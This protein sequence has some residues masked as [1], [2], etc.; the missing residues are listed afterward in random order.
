MRSMNRSFLFAAALAV[1]GTASAQQWAGLIDPQRAVDWSQAGVPGGIPSR[2]TICSTLNPGATS[3]Q[4]NSAIASCPAN[5]VVYLNAGTYTLSGGINFNNKSNVT[6]RGAG[7]NQTIINFSGGADCIGIEAD[8][9]VGNSGYADPASPPFS[10][11]WTGGL[12]KGSTTV[13]LSSTSGL[14]V[15]QLL[16]LD[17]LNE[18][19]DTGDIWNCST[20]GTCSNEGPA[21]GGRNNRGQ[22]QV[23]RVTAVSGNNVSISPGVA[24]PNFRSGQSP[25]AWTGYTPIQGVGIED[26]RI[27]N[28]QSGANGIV[29]LTAYASWVKNVTSTY[30]GRAHVWV[31]LGKNITVRDSYFYEGNSHASQSYGV[32]L[33]QASDVLVENN[34]IDRVTAALIA[35]G[36]ATGSVIA[37]NYVYQTVYAT[38]SWMIPS[39][40]HHATGVNMMLHEGNDSTGW[41]GDNVHGPGVMLTLFRNRFVGSNPGKVETSQT[42]PIQPYH[43]WRYLNV[44]GNVLGDGVT[45]KVY[46]CSPASASTSDCGAGQDHSIYVLGWSNNGGS[47]SSMPNDPKVASTMFRWGNWDTVTQTSHFDAAEVPSGISPYKNALPASQTLPAS[48]YRSGKPTWWG[49]QPW[50]AIGPDVTGGD[51]AGTGGHMYKI[52]ARLCYENTSKTSG[53]LNFN[54]N[55]CYANVPPPK[56]MSININ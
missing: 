32:E 50:P 20:A 7:P 29:F 17:Q 43:F 30:G 10:A 52:P 22:L 28:Q 41:M 39:N 40:T 8:I 33:F 48:L 54:A 21:G 5:Q 38:S 13:T 36:P 47:K 31:W 9:C 18:S 4:I 55:A 3:S 19:A 49:S 45:Q 53:V 24:M 12:A 14:A 15:G 16:I 51:V 6:I 37:Y 27:N 44:I 42:I 1:A 46:E 25:G 35:N 34:I 2:T 11:N 23:V 26:L 56:P